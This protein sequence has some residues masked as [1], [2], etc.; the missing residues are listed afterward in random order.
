MKRLYLIFAIFVLCFAFTLPARAGGWAVVTLTEFPKQVVAGD[1]FTIEFAVRQHGT[2]LTSSF[3]EPLVYATHLDTGERFE[4]RAKVT[5]RTGYFTAELVFPE[6]GAWDWSIGI[7]NERAYAQP[8]PPLNVQPAIFSVSPTPETIAMPIVLG[9]VGVLTFLGAGAVFVTT[10]TRWALGIGIAGLL[11]TVIGVAGA[12]QKPASAATVVPQNLPVADPVEVG[13]ALIL[14]KG[15]LVCHSHSEAGFKFTGIQT[16]IGPDLATLK[17]PP[18]YIEVWLKDPAEI[19]P[20]TLMPNLELKETEIQ[21]L[22][23]F[24]TAEE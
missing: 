17:Y 10:R 1:P 14:A 12:G 9:V 3:G 8:M 2:H 4:V 21:A 11:L 16:N 5:E 7:Y 19:K 6:S 20:K 23:A 24:L 22:T 15:C 18:E 13:R